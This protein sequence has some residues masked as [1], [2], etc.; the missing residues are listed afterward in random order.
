ME[1]GFR[2]DELEQ[3]WQDRIDLEHDL[4]LF[5]KEDRDLM[6]RFGF[7][8]VEDLYGT[9]TEIPKQCPTCGHQW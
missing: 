3:C 4:D 6:I 2:I 1:S 5:W 7:R 9:G 8:P